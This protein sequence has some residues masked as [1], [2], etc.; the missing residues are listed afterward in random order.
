MHST[1][2]HFAADVR[3]VVE[4]CSHSGWLAEASRQTVG[5]EGIMLWKKRISSVDLLAFLYATKSF[6][7]SNN[8]LVGVH[9]RIATS[10]FCCMSC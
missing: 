1:T 6:L 7:K 4:V 3:V 5:T 10:L 8:G 2:A 9:P